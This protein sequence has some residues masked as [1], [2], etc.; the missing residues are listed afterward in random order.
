VSFRASAASRGIA[1][2]PSE[3]FLDIRARLRAPPLNGRF[4]AEAA[5]SAENAFRGRALGTGAERLSSHDSESKDFGVGIQPCAAPWSFSVLRDVRG[6]R[7]ISSCRAD[8]RSRALYPHD[9]DS[10]FA[11]RA[12]LGMTPSAVRSE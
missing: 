6:L 4:H 10:D 8:G 7:V 1:I 9:R 5:E 2:V 3:S 11:L 12:P